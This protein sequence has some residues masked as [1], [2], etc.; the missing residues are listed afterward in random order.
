MIT[1]IRLEVSFAQIAV[2][3]SSLDQPFN[4]WTER[5]VS[6]GFAWR[7]GSVSFRTLAEDGQHVIE[8]Q[9]VNHV[10][11]VQQGAIRAIDVPFD[12]PPDS[13]IEIGSIFDS[14]PL[15]L[16]AGPYLLRCEFM[17][18]DDSGDERVRLTFATGDT[19][20]FALLRTDPELSVTKELTLTARP[21]SF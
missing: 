13:N 1:S 17:G 21:A 2:F 19:P 16:P 6:Q 9:V 14:T 4:D 7:L 20:R 3:W 8:I 12:V 15:S 18:R 10:S 5:H 11:D